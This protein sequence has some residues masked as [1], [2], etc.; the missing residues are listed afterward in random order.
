MRLQAG[1]IVGVEG[2]GL[3]C[4]LSEHIF[5]P[6]TRLYHF[7]LVGDHL[8][9]ENDYVILES[10]ASGV[11]LGRLSWYENREY[12][13]FRITEPDSK[14]LG[15]RATRLASKFGRRH[16]DFML[17]P[18]LLFGVMKCWWEQLIKERKIRRIRPDELSYTR[19]KAFVCT[20]FA[21]EVWRLVNYPVIKGIT[22][23]PSAYVQAC[24]N[25]RLQV[26]WVNKLW[27]R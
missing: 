10:I 20:E 14:R 21:S 18:K 13:V 2:K 7:L 9:R 1:D 16:Y 12:T 15:M 22:S 23:L 3:L 4:W 11:R 6:Q 27:R 5:E 25:G 26:V 17:Y 8:P 24:Y 19:D